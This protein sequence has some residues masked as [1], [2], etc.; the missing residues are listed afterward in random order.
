M[1]K[2]IIIDELKSAI[3]VDTLETYRITKFGRIEIERSIP[4]SE[5]EVGYRFYALRHLTNKDNKCPQNI[6]NELNKEI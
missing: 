3:D 2:L 5:Q 4:L 6:L 1:Q